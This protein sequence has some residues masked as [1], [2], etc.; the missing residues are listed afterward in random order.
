MTWILIADDH[1]ELREGLAEVFRVEGFRVGL[2]ADGIELLRILGETAPASAVVLLDLLMPHMSG[3]EVL[4]AMRPRHVPVVVLTGVALSAE[5]LVSLG[6]EEVLSK[7][8]AVEPL[9]GAVQ[10]A[11]GRV[12]R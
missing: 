8:I 12:A 5:E 7:P 2:A 6:V 9:L 10:R 1:D 11:L 4:H 3:L